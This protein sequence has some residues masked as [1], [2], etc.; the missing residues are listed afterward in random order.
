MAVGSRLSV[1]AFP[2]EGPAELTI[3]IPVRSLIWD[4]GK[5]GGFKQATLGVLTAYAGGGA[6]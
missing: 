3:Q 5:F 1:R 2:G 6:A 4:S